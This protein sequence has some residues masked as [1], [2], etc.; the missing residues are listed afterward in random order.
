MYVVGGKWKISI[1]ASLSFG[2]KR[3]SEVLK[4]IERI[5]GKMLSRELKEMETNKLLTRTV[6]STR[7]TAVQY[8]LTDYSHQLMPVINKLAEWGVNHRQELFG[9]QRS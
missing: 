5:S 4:D 3:Y 9:K 8:E 6:L 1:I 2:P 7:P